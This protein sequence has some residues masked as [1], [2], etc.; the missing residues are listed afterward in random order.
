LDIA[1][2]VVQ[3]VSAIS[4]YAI[5]T[6]RVTYNPASDL[7]ETLRTRKVT[8]RAALSRVELPELLDKLNA[9][10]G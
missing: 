9:Y 8:H 3:R 1:S 4:R 6:G 2:R 10:D 5:S 7:V